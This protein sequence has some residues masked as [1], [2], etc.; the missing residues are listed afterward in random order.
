MY[1]HIH[2]YT[3]N[4]NPCQGQIVK[5]AENSPATK[6]G[7]PSLTW[8]IYI[9]RI[10]KVIL[11]RSSIDIYIHISRIFRMIHTIEIL[12]VSFERKKVYITYIFSLGRLYLDYFGVCSFSQFYYF[13]YVRPTVWGKTI[14]LMFFPK[15]H[16]LFAE[17]GRPVGPID[18]WC[19]MIKMTMHAMGPPEVK[20]HQVDFWG[21]PGWE[22]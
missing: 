2:I 11:H 3:R 9:N 10:I 20:W 21:V 14:K 15:S 13:I 22:R 7:G 19:A 12:V 8:S 18:W 16:V 6:N 4:T 1:I 17:E 5:Q